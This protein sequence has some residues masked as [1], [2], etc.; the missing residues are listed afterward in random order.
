MRAVAL[1]AS[2]FAVLPA[3]PGTGVPHFVD[4]VHFVTLESP[5]RTADRR[6]IEVAEV[7]SYDCLH[8]FGFEP[9]LQAWSRRQKRDVHVV[10]VHASTRAHAEPLIRGY[11]TV[12]ALRLPEKAHA[13]VFSRVQLDH[14]P[15][16]TAAEWAELLSAYGADRDQVLQVYASPAVT[17]QVR[18]A[19]ARARC[20]DLELGGGGAPRL[21]VN[22]KYVVTPDPVGPQEQA[23]AVVDYLVSRERAAAR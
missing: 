2:L 7:V 16:A 4:G 20:Y 11:Y 3:L 6:R 10:Q 23:L 15:P 21:I 13:E 17:G 8:C 9:L 22:G 1:L 18:E 14:Q 19:Q 12:R 5:F